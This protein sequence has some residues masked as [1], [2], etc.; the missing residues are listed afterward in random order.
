MEQNNFEKQVHQ[1]MEE[2]NILPSETSW[3]NIEKQIG[4]KSRRRNLI[5]MLLFFVSILLFTSLYLFLNSLKNTALKF[6]NEP[7]QLVKNKIEKENPSYQPSV[8]INKNGTNTTRKMEKRSSKSSITSIKKISPSNTIQSNLHNKV[9]I[10][11][12][13]QFAERESNKSQIALDNKIKNAE[14]SAAAIDTGSKNNELYKKDSTIKSSRIETNAEN[15]KEKAP[16]KKDIE[17]EITVDENLKILSVEKKKHWQFGFIFS[18]GTSFAGHDP[19]TLNKSADY[20]ASPITSGGIPNN[21]YLPS[22]TKNSIA[23]TAGIFIQK[24]ISSNNKISLGF[25]YKYY[26]IKNK[27]GNKIDSAQS[28]Y[29]SSAQVNNF[30][31]EFNFLEIP[32]TF[33]LRLNH[34]KSLPIYWDAGISISELVNTNA[35]QFK[36][37]QGI[38][39]TDNS[40][41]NKTQIG[42]RT[43]FS[44]TLFCERKNSVNIGP[45][46]YFDATKLANKGLY[47]KT[48][49]S[50]IGISA[51]ILFNKK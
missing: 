6:E 50:F 24:N 33:K 27:I 12:G 1:K 48:H 37:D 38:Y 31:S 51:E 44:A 7:N 10:K 8:Q 2:L 36:N 19:F 3:A 47:N 41:F 49:F 25:N 16:Y 5:F 35:L 34:N 11:R 32:V 23:F 9:F 20:L 46:F 13:L 14:K 17:K 30:R 45:Y 29:Y 40:L 15:I 42:F 21:N 43:G 39:Y 28:A 22:A 18:G 4:Q 26:S